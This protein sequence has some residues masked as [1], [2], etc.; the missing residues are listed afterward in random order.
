V[1]LIAGLG[2]PGAQYERT[3]HNIG[4]MAVDR[5]VERVG[6]FFQRNKRF[7]ADAAE[8]RLAGESALVLKPETFMNLSGR[9]VQPAMQF[10]KVALDDVMVVHD[11]LDLLPGAV[12]LKCGGG[13][14]GHNGLKSISGLLGPEYVRLRLGIGKAPA[15]V[16]TAS[17]VLAPFS[18]AEKTLLDAQ[19]ERACDALELWMR[20]GLE[21][22]TREIHSR[23]PIV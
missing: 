8:V 21:A 17:Y 15:G 4:F 7:Q 12:R 23:L 19:I 2:N 18:A 20:E 14:A 16:N 13:T 10:Y 9:A 6:G 11:E 5:F 3:R 22:A 1:K